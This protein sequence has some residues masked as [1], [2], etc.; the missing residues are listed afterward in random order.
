MPMT[1]PQATKMVRRG[2][3]VVLIGGFDKGETSIPL[4]WQRMQ[5][6]EIQLILSASFAYRDIYAEQGEIVQLI[7]KGKLPVAKLITHRFKLDEINEAFDVANDKAN[8][9]A[10][11]VAIGIGDD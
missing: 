7:A 9:G 11:F 10:V 2:G 6:S 1:L 5:M 3:K 4:E 8:T